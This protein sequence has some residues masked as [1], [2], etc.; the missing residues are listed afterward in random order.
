MIHETGEAMTRELECLKNLHDLLGIPIYVIS[1]GKCTFCRPEET[2]NCFPQ[3]A[4][5][6]C[7]ERML[8]AAQKHNNPIAV[9]AEYFGFSSQSHFGSCFKKLYGMTPNEYRRLNAR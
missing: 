2:E 4:D 7:A 8:E 5:P 1:A 3:E 6:D 9:I